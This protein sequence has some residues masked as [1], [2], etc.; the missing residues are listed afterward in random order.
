MTRIEDDD[1]LL[2]MKDE[3]ELKER[4]RMNYGIRQ[5]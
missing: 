4:K 1:Y 3:E 2:Y 5:S